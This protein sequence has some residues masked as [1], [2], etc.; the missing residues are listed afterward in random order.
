MEGLTD[1]YF[2]NAELEKIDITWAGEKYTHKKWYN[3]TNGFVE[4][5]LKEENEEVCDR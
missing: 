2:A 4:E 1:N 5:F 3:N